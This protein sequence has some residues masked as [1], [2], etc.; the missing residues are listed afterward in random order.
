M[1]LLTSFKIATSSLTLL[2]AFSTSVGMMKHRNMG[3]YRCFMR[4]KS[5]Q[6][7]IEGIQAKLC[8]SKKRPELL[9]LPKN[10]TDIVSCIANWILTV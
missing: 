10:K 6:F 1:K 4:L 2:Q 9:L 8:N 5:S 3:M 7:P